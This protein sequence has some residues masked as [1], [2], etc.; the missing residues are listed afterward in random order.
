MVLKERKNRKEKVKSLCHSDKD[1]Q[2]ALSQHKLEDME[3]QHK[4]QVELNKKIS[5]K[6]KHFQKQNLE[7]IKIAEEKISELSGKVH[8]EAVQREDLVGRLTDAERLINLLSEENARLTKEISRREELLVS[9]QS[10]IEEFKYMREDGDLRRRAEEF[11]KTR[12]LRGWLTELRT[13]CSIQKSIRR[14]T[15]KRERSEFMNLGRRFWGRWRV[16][17]VAGLM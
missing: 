10:I 15:Q 17:F 4:Q 7:N 12:I 1:L 16:L 14:M 2:L 9:N 6:L 11:Q 5:G 13:N 3:K 8:E